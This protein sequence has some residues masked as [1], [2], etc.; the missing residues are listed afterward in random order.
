LLG[1]PNT[2]KQVYIGVLT[3]VLAALFIQPLLNLLWGLLNGATTAIGGALSDVIYRNAARGLDEHYS[4]L[5]LSLVMSLMLGVFTSFTVLPFLLRRSRK[6]ALEGREKVVHK[7]RWAVTILGVLGVVLPLILLTIE[8]GTYK[9]NS[10]F[11]QYMAA[12]SPYVTDLDAKK[13]R[14]RWA[15]MRTRADF[16]SIS[17]DLQ[18]IASDNAIVL[19]KPRGFNTPF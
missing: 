19:P 5:L 12:T 4:F 1:D 9:L 6:E 17:S 7:L 16:E 15:L 8:F 3:S 2:R 10:S 13:L 14:S 11:N 18:K